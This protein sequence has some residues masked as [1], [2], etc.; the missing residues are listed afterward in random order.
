MLFVSYSLR[1]YPEDLKSHLHMLFQYPLYGDM[2]FISRVCEE[3]WNICVFVGEGG[4]VYITQ[5][6]L[7]SYFGSFFI[8]V[9]TFYSS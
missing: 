8:F 1:E 9:F 2:T 5:E 4:L 6:I 3:Y 7:L